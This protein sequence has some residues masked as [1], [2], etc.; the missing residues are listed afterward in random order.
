MTQLTQGAF[1]EQLNTKFWLK[2]TGHDPI[3]LDLI[4][5]SELNLT[6]GTEAF[7]ILFKGPKEFVLQQGTY[8][9]EHDAMGTFHILLV[10]V[11]RNDEGTEYEAVFNRLLKRDSQQK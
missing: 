5:V 3:E 11:G 6:F 7:S 4:K 10:P 8:Q 9:L 2:L 1:A